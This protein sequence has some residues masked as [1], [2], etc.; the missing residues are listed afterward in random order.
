M[1]QPNLCITSNIT[2]FFINL[3]FNIL[4][5]NS[6]IINIAEFNQELR[7][8]GYDNPESILQGL[9]TE[10]IEIKNSHIAKIYKDFCQ[11]VCFFD[12]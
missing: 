12:I 7:R 6:N 5:I 3:K 9:W 1:D 8:N 11:K 4:I 10:Q 2:R